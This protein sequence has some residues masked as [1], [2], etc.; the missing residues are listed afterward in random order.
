MLDKGNCVVEKLEWC[1]VGIGKVLK[2]KIGLTMGGR[3]KGE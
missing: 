3:D 1:V 2:N